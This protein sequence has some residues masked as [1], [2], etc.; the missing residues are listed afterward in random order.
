[1]TLFRS[2]ILLLA[3]AQHLNFGH[4]QEKL[5][6][7]LIIGDSV[8]HQPA[9]ETARA[10]EGKVEIVLARLGPGEVCNTGTALEKLDD[11]LAE[12]EWDLVHFNFG[13]GDLV[14]RAPSMRAFR[15][16]PR[17]AGGERATSPEQYEKNLRNLVR[18]L[19]KDAAGAKLVWASTTP[20]RHSSTDVFA[21]GSEIDYNAIAARVMAEHQVPT[22][23]M[24]HYVRSLIDMGKPASHGADPFHF[25]KKPIHQ[26]IVASIC[27][28]LGIPEPGAGN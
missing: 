16:Y 15:V 17:H 24:Y 19:K 4:A 25:D 2:I 27:S 13:L 11:W 14:Y 20:I 9:A 8:Y 21:L 26:P 3:I 18:R 10:L 22:N 6:R 28:R 12:G 5:P 1:M 23:D 7:V